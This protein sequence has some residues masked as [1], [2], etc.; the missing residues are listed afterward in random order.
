MKNLKFVMSILVYSSMLT[1]T[2]NGQ[3][4]VIAVKSQA[5]EM[6]EVLDRDDNFGEIN[7]RYMNIQVD[8][9]Q[10]FGEQ[11]MYVEYR[12]GLQDTISFK[13]LPDSLVIQ[14]TRTIGFNYPQETK[15]IG[16]PDGVY[17]GACDTKGIKKNSLAIWGVL[18][19]FLFVGGMV[20]RR[21][22]KS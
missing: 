17:Q 21:K 8:S 3:T 16:F 7:P 1:Y 19:S 14:Y 11:K 9:V 6:A 12:K 10:F 13:E 4:N 15:F 20:G 18:L 5:G 2:V 22:L